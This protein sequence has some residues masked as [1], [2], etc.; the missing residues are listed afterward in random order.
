MGSPHH[1][2]GAS[3]LLS[4]D[5]ASLEFQA[6]SL[7][8]ESLAHPQRT[9]L[10]G[11]VQQSVNKKSAARYFLDDVGG[12]NKAAVAKFLAD[13][14]S[15]LRKCLS[16]LSFASILLTNSSARPTICKNLDPS[17]K[18]II[19]RRDEGRC[20]ISKVD[21][22]QKYDEDPLPMHIVSPTLFQ[23]DDMVRDVRTRRP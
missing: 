18:W 16:P 2:S 17:L 20:C 12:H 14:I 7:I 22:K 9:L 10:I 21:D 19:W 3:H 15:L 13:W 23:D 4:C 11:F 1:I 8:I 5:E 6:I